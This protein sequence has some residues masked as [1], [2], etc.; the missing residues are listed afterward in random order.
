MFCSDCTDFR[1][2]TRDPKDTSVVVS[3]RACRPCF[4][5]FR[6]K[7]IRGQKAKPGMTDGATKRRNSKAEQHPPQQHDEHTKREV[8]M[9]P[10]HQ[11]EGEDDDITGHETIRDEEDE[12]HTQYAAD[13]QPHP[14]S[15]VMGDVQRAE[16]D[17]DTVMAAQG[18]VVLP[19]KSANGGLQF[20]P[21]ESS[22]SVSAPATADKDSAVSGSEKDEFDRSSGGAVEGSEEILHIPS[23]ALASVKHSSLT[24]N[25]ARSVSAVEDTDGIMNVPSDALATVK[26]GNVNTMTQS[27]QADGGE[28]AWSER[29]VESHIVAPTPTA[30]VP[31]L[32]N[33]AAKQEQ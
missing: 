27:S 6:G 16:V 17:R 1:L 23:D 26:H 25:T 19:S 12:D 21:V 30:A 28:V 22:T 18:S 8:E 15:L 4:D 31:M 2:L 32:F 14:I 3:V 7:K 20:V 24:T 11:F 33:L 9:P 10:Q 13:A 5:K 29:N